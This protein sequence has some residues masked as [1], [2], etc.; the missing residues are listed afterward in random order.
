MEEPHNVKRMLEKT[1]ELMKISEPK[2]VEQN[3]N[4]N[5]E[6]SKC[7]NQFMFG[8]TQLLEIDVPPKNGDK[9]SLVI[10]EEVSKSFKEHS[11][12]CQGKL[13]ISA[14][15][16]LLFIYFNEPRNMQIPLYFS[17]LGEA[18]KYKSHVREVGEDIPFKYETHFVNDNLQFM[19]KDGVTKLSTST[20]FEE[21]VKILVLSRHES[22]KKE[23]EHVPPFSENAMRS[24]RKKA[25]KM[26]LHDRHFQQLL[27]KRENAASYERNPQR[28]STKEE[29][30]K[31]YASSGKRQKVEERRQEK[32]EE[33]GRS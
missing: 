19:N 30:D 13:C 8:T 24:I 21:N 11:G 25:D 23:P 18:F 10:E 1:L 17:L 14:K 26:T 31:E 29:Y 7:N 5:M 15:Q 2:T 9:L 33:T 22:I 16:S 32:D 28:K 20:D 4:L 6:C 12:V 27:K 3:M